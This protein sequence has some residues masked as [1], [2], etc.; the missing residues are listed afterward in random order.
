MLE[1][2]KHEKSV[3]I[4]GHVTCLRAQRNYMVQTE[5]Q[6]MFLYDSVLEGVASGN[7]EVPARNLYTHI[8]RLMT[9]DTQG[10]TLMETEFKV[11]NKFLNKVFDMNIQLIKK[12]CEILFAEIIFIQTL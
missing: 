2:S 6:Y 10:M 9:V 11:Y 7:T 5:D 8:Q 12:S 3:D 1:R 4:Y